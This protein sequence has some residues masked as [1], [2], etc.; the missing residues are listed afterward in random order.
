[1]AISGGRN[2]K[3]FRASL[4]TAAPPT[5][6]T[7]SSPGRARKVRAIA[8]PRSFMPAGM[9]CVSLA[10]R[11][12]PSRISASCTRLRRCRGRRRAP[13]TG[14]AARTRRTAATSPLGSTMSRRRDSAARSTGNFA[15]EKLGLITTGLERMPR[16]SAL[17]RERFADRDM[18]KVVRLLAAAGY[19][20][21]SLPFLRALG[22]SVDTPGEVA[23]AVGAGAPYRA[24]PRRP[25]PPRPPRRSVAL[26]SRACPRSSSAFRRSFGRP[27]PSTARLF[28]RSFARR[29]LS[30]TPRSATSARAA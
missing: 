21:R 24:V 27:T 4:S 10:I 19:A 12:A 9:R 29:V 22:E 2:G 23:L 14:S 20:D 5:S 26:K 13:P 11:S 1:M 15:R 8:S 16:P 6:P 7:K 30:T 18:V 25:S 17:D 3:A 28:T